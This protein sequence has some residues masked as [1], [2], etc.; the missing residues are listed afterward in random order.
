[1]LEAADYRVHRGAIDGVDVVQL[2][3]QARDVLVSVAPGIGNM[4][5]EMKVRGKNLLW[6][7]FSSPAEL[8]AKPTFCCIPFLAPWANRLD[9]LE[10]WANGKK[11]A[12][13]AGL[14]NLRRDAHRSRSTG[15]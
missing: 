13:N 10:Y 7:P 12:L 3:D 5:Y 6:S 4:A 9:G 11:Y 14:G 8:Q 15:C 1:M 2:F